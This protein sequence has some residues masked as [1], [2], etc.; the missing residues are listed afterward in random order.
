M[1]LKQHLPGDFPQ[2]FSL[3]V[4][5]NLGHPHLLPCSQLSSLFTKMSLQWV[6]HSL[7]YFITIFSFVLLTYLLYLIYFSFSYSSFWYCLDL[8]SLYHSKLSTNKNGEWSIK[9]TFH[10]APDKMKILKY[11]FVFL[12]KEKILRCKISCFTHIE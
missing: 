2:G 5:P 10:E 8:H 6:P 12:N 3:P 1:V 7:S 4:S 9:E 11:E